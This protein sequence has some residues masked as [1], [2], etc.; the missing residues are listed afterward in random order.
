MIYIGTFGTIHH[1]IFL[2]KAT[3]LIA[4]AGREGSRLRSD[5]HNVATVMSQQPT[6]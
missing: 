6:R 3:S 2:S 1:R 5:F 4:G